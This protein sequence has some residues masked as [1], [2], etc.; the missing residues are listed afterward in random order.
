ML[1]LRFFCRKGHAYLDLQVGF[2]SLTTRSDSLH[3]AGRQLCVGETLSL[4]V[5]VAQLHVVLL[6]LHVSL[7]T[8]A[9]HTALLITLRFLGGGMIRRVNFHSFRVGRGE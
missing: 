8:S 7:H 5:T 9:E 2:T 4:R 6:G 1:I 3:R